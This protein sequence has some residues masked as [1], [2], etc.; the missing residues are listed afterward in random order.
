MKEF[1]KDKIGLELVLEELNRHVFFKMGKNML[2]ILN[3]K[4]ALNE[5]D[6]NHGVMTLPVINHFAFE[7]KKADF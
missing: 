7:I 6:T 3:P 4:V 1:Y 5:K 2:L